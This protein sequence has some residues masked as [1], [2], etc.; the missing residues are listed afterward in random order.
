MFLLNCINLW[1]VLFHALLAVTGLDPKLLQSSA[2]DVHR[3]Q[4]VQFDVPFRRSRSKMQNKTNEI[5]S[6][7]DRR[8][9]A[10][11]FP[12]VLAL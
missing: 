3:W 8:N 2:Q 7:N 6:A 10:Q 11:N 9:M 4:E 1:S 5:H 12:T